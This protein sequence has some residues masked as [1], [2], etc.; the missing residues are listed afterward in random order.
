MKIRHLY[1]E[2]VT[3]SSAPWHNSCSGHQKDHQHQT[4]KIW[5]MRMSIKNTLRS[6]RAHNV[7]A[8]VKPNYE[9]K[10]REFLLKAVKFPSL[11]STPSPR[12]RLVC[13]ALKITDSAGIDLCNEFHQNPYDMLCKAQAPRIKPDSKSLSE[14]HELECNCCKQCIQC[15]CRGVTEEGFCHSACS[16]E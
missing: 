8:I 15:P 14:A 12:W 10:V 13:N 2:S 16:C 9:I 6:A 1:R 4:Y 11:L 3:K 7:T 5:I